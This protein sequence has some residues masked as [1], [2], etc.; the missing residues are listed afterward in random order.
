MRE[1]ITIVDLILPV[2]SLPF[3]RGDCGAVLLLP[4]KRVFPT[5][6]VR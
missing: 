4:G 1:G 3:V 5:R 2:L 6:K